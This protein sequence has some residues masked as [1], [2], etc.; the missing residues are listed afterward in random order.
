M[1]LLNPPRSQQLTQLDILAIFWDSVKQ[2]KVILVWT[3]TTDTPVL[4][5][6]NWLN[7]LSFGLSV[8]LRISLEF[9]LRTS[10]VAGFERTLSPSIQSIPTTFVLDKEGITQMLI[11][12]KIAFECTCG[13]KD[14][15]KMTRCTYWGENSFKSGCKK[16]LVFIKWEIKV[17]VLVRI[18]YIMITSNWGYHRTVVG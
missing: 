8:Y 5:F 11:L 16:G 15:A 7:W 4:Y 1:I 9:I 18:C 6:S 17:V 10:L 14:T 3:V 13:L 12:R 2:V